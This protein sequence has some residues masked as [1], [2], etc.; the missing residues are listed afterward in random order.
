MSST[1]ASRANA[2]PAARAR[3][4]A[5]VSSLVLGATLLLAGR[6]PSRA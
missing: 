3:I 5:Q 6:S 2:I 1:Q 4:R